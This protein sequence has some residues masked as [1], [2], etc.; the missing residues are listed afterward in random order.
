MASDQLESRLKP[1]EC[2]TAMT[3][4]DHANGCFLPPSD[5]AAKFY[6]DCRKLAAIV[7]SAITSHDPI[8]DLIRD[9]PDHIFL[10]AADGTLLGNNTAYESMFAN[11]V[12]P[13]GRQGEAF[14][15]ESILPF[16]RNSDAMILAGADDVMF[17]HSGRDSEGQLAWFRTFKASLLGLGHPCLAILGISRLIST[18]PDD[19]AMKLFPLSHSWALFSSLRDRERE[20]AAATARGERTKLIAQRLDCSE[21]TVE[22][23][24]N[25]VMKT[26]SLESPAELIK[27]MVRL[28][29]SGFG[30]FGL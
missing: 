1:I 23:S 21:K 22:N 17:W 26:L 13:I 28:Q 29:D 7:R 11:G 25:A 18:D 10:K 24:R 15:H 3:T 20:I 16:S 14:L 27:L 8:A 19:R 6:Q 5:D 4:S 9:L 12:A 2:G 30:D